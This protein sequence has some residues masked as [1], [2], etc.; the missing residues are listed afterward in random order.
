MPCKPLLLKWYL[1]NVLRKITTEGDEIEELNVTQQ[2]GT[3]K[4]G[5]AQHD[6]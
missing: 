6:F 3:G 4:I 1:Q 5:K 2:L